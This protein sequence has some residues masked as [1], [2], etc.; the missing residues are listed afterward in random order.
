LTTSSHVEGFHSIFN[1]SKTVRSIEK[2]KIALNATALL[3]PLT[4]IGQYTYHLA[5]GLQAL[6]EVELDL[7]YGS[8]W[9]EELRNSPVIGIAV[10][11]Y[12]LKL[13]TPNSY[14]VGRFLQQRNFTSG[15]LSN[16]PEVYHEPN[17][18][19]FKFN[20]PSVI[21]VH[22][23]SWIRF[24]HTHPV[25]RVRAMDT[26]FEQGLRRAALILT[27]SE[28]VKRELMAVFGIQAERIKP[29]LLGVEPL[30][31]PRTAEDTRSVLA[32]HDLV[33][34]QYLLAVG[35][36]EPRKNLQV[37]L[38][39]YM[40]LPQQ[41]RKRFPLVLVGMKGWRTSELEKQI[42]PL[43]RAG[44]VRQIG[45]L[46]R[47]ELAMVIAGALTLIYPSIYEGFGLPPLEAMAC[48][49]PVIASDISSLPEVVG[50][51]GL[52]I[53]PHDDTA[54]AEVIQKLIMDTD[55]RRQLSQKALTRSAEFTWDKC[56]TKTVDVYR[57]A[58]QGG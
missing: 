42:A 19:A 41:V 2:M 54:L 48:G 33:H 7:F 22:D 35:T 26:Y 30:F 17:F 20:G 52:L 11:K 21:T 31:H 23:L 44:E 15:V 29:V 55:L 36:L 1:Q 43:V 6:P 10:I 4:G 27:D 32:R 39:A 9:N 57:Q 16:R 25:E 34:G 46:P 51:T 45:Y 40:Q 24:P 38:R 47:E 50:D 8:Y 56:V 53:N 14:S 5:K 3:S 58:L 49:V 18:L 13:I 12:L 37:A 28:F